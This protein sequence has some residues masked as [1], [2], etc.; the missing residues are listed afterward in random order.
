MASTEFDFRLPGRFG[1]PPPPVPRVPQVEPNVCL[2]E[3]LTTDDAGQP[4]MQPWAMPRLVADERA[5]S[6]GD[7]AI[8]KPLTTP[9]GKLLIEHK[10][11]WRNDTPVDQPVMMRVIRGPRYWLTSQPNA[12][13]FRDRWTYA[14]DAEP[15]E[16]LTTSIFDGRCGSA[17]D[18]GTNSVAEPNPGQQ[19]MWLDVNT[20][21]TWLPYELAPN[22]L[23][24]MWYRCYVWTPGP[25]S[26]NANKNTPQHT[27]YAR[28]ARLQLWV[29]PQPGSLVSG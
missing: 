16:P 18:F 14:V 29:Y 9:P 27:A 6:G 11:R 25:W 3:N 20:A 19:R 21:D 26:D 17:I 13:Q 7:G 28:W 8:L 22:E 4:W 5:L 15:E 12:I 1:D 24:T 23:F 10:V 2:D